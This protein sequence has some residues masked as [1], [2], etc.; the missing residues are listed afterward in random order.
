MPFFSSQSHF[1]FRRFRLHTLTDTDAK[2]TAEA[3]H[4][5]WRTSREDSTC[6][7]SQACRLRNCESILCACQCLEYLKYLRIFRIPKWF[8][9]SESD[10]PGSTSMPLTR[11]FQPCCLDR[12][13][14]WPM[15]QACA[16]PQHQHFRAF[17][18]LKMFYCKL[19]NI[20]QDNLGCLKYSIEETWHLLI[21][22][23]VYLLNFSW[24]GSSVLPEVLNWKW[25]GEPLYSVA[26]FAG[27]ACAAVHVPFAPVC[28]L[29]PDQRL[30]ASPQFHP[31]LC[32]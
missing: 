7:H 32:F 11:D 30:T 8:E 20:V 25:C 13:E 28:T 29:H 3:K 23:I 10:A 18:S 14:K 19:I 2:A 31:V 6:H 27:A 12:L 1:R 15:P 24:A 26:S 9:Y 17:H 4:A 21:F 22:L 16:L 5:S